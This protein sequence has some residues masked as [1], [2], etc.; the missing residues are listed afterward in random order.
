MSTRPGAPYKD[1]VEENGKVLIYEGHDNPVPGGG[2]RPK[3]VD[4]ESKTPEGGLTQNGL[5]YEA[6]QKYKDGRSP[7]E[8][9]KSMRRFELAYGFTTVFSSCLMLQRWRLGEDVCSSSA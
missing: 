5:F 4:Q 3:E 9:V 2:R 7:T 8:I 6:A 1:R